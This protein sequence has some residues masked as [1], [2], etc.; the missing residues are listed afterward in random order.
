MSL[1]GTTRILHIL[2]PAREGGLESVVAMLSERQGRDRV[3]VA[4]VLSP[5]EAENHPFVSRLERARIPATRV[6]VGARGYFREYHL[7]GD[8]VRRIRPDVIHTHGYRSDV[9]GTIVALKHRVPAVSTVHGFVGGGIR[10]YVNERIQCVALR[11]AAV[12][13]AVSRPLVGRLSRAGI[14]RDR[15][16]F[17]PNGFDPPSNISTRIEARRMLGIDADSLVA[18]WIGRLS[19][20]KGPDVMLAALAK[21]NP[22]WQVSVIGEGREGARLKKKAIDL[23]IGERIKWH[24]AVAN[25][26]TL[27]PAFDAF[28]LSSRTEGT[29]IALLEAMFARIPIV[30]TRVGGVPD[31]VTPDHALI[32]P[33]E[34]A[35]AVAEALAEI[36]REPGA[37]KARADR[38]YNRVVSEFSAD[39]WVAA[40]EEVYRVAC[41]FGSSERG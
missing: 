30:T 34:D 7:L 38:A 35:S 39:R 4:V 14:A 3:H 18:G 27:L 12:V 9:V 23:G 20:E 5:N 17:V 26:A 6:V 15:I 19:Y 24:G 32:V 29:P 25:A 28:V 21:A 1:S 31:V 22:S 16:R 13:L 33:S 37:A 10:D 11:R 40:V 36:Q 8:V 2:A 41:A